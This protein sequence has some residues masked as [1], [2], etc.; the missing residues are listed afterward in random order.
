MRSSWCL[1]HK[2]LY[3][4]NLWYI[5]KN[6]QNGN[7]SI[8]GLRQHLR[9]CV[10]T[11]FR[12]MIRQFSS[13][14]NASW[15]RMPSYHHGELFCDPS[16]SLRCQLFISLCYCRIAL[17]LLV[18]IIWK[19]KLLIYTEWFSMIRFLFLKVSLNFKNHI[20]KE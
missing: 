20:Y 12:L 17:P 9:V 5:F 18:T 1:K 7:L 10:A 13:R 3:A 19:S 6:K 11:Q 8:H 16:I 4:F 2:C 14:F 15:S